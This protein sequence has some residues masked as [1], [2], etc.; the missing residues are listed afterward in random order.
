MSLGCLGFAADND[1][2]STMRRGGGS[3]GAPGLPSSAEVGLP[4]K[5]GVPPVKGS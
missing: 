2:A 1:S 3:G 4:R 5:A